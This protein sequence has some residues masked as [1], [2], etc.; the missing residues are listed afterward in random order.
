LKH[1]CI[2]SPQVR[3]Y[4]EGKGEI[5]NGNLEIELPSY[6]KH[7]VESK[8][9]II[10]LTKYSKGD[11]WVEKE[12][13]QNNKVIVSGIEGTK[14]SWLISGIRKGYTDYKPEYINK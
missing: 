4:Y 3:V 13:Y 1:S 10:H 9:E 12:D 14:F 2:E 6:F 5:R 7:L 8:T 11:V